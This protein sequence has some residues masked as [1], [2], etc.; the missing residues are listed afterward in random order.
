V[1]SAQTVFTWRLGCF[2]RVVSVVPEFAAGWRRVTR[3]YRFQPVT[4]SRPQAGKRNVSVRCTCCNAVVTIQVHSR[5][6]V[7]RMGR[8]GC[9]GWVGIFVPLA[10][11]FL[12]MAAEEGSFGV[13]MAV[14]ACF[15]ASLPAWIV[16]YV[17]D[18][19]ARPRIVNT[20]WGPDTPAYSTAIQRHH[21]LMTP[22]GLELV[23]YPGEYTLRWRFLRG[24]DPDQEGGC[25]S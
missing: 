1:R 22:E 9:L 25:R 13:G 11:V 5:S 17:I 24:E 14:F 8:L 10:I 21:I 18:N 12:R 16:W 3:E 7:R 20:D 2:Q 4:L 23:V 6:Y 19:L 15:V